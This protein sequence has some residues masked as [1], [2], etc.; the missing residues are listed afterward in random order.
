LA[1]SFA[2]EINNPLHALL[3]LFSLIQKD[4]SLSGETRQYLELAQQ[5][6]ERMSHIA[7]AAME[8]FRDHADPG[9]TRTNIPQLLTSVIEFYRS[10]F[11]SGGITVNARYCTDGTLRV[12]SGVLRQAFSNL[13]LN[14]ADAVPEGGTIHARVSTAHEWSG[15]KR[16]GLRVTVA[17]NGCGIAAVDLPKIMR[18]SFTTK[19]SAGNGLGLSVVQDAVLRN[20]G[21]LRVRS[22]IDK[23][24][25]GTVFAMFLPSV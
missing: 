25:H 10:R 21:T 11:N 16:H 14:S 13:L 5:E 15:Q 19:G 8:R 9:T 12:E 23:N 2:H 7:H 18:P 4:A 20:C 17:D 3:N 22:S 24:R 6:A 1:A